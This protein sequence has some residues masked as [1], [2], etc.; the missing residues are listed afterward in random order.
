VKTTVTKAIATV[1]Q[2]GPAVTLASGTCTTALTAAADDDDVHAG[3]AVVVSGKLTRTAPGGSELPA[4]GERVTVYSLVAGATRWTPAGNGLTGADGSY[5]VTTKPLVNATLQARFVARKGFEAATGADIPVAVTPRATAVTAALSAA[6]SMAGAPVTVTGTLTQEG[7]SGM[8]PMK[9]TKVQVTYPL[10]GGK[11]G[12]ANATTKVDGSYTAVIKP[13]LTGTVSVKYAGK[14]GWDTT[15]KDLSITV[16]DWDSTLTMTAVRG[17]T[18]SVTVSGKL[19]ITDVDGNTVPKASAQ[20]EVTYQAAATTTKTV[21][22]TTKATGEF[23]LTVKPLATGDVTA[24]FAGLAGFG[25]A[26]A[27]PVTISVS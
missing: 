2:A 15:S 16:D 26:T 21:K 9:S 12:I 13:I 1:T 4:A 18:G 10:P 27:T 6:E 14:P 17:A 25:A 11:T 22:A 8:E 19:T 24:K 7:S 5:A 23:T 20:I 3:D